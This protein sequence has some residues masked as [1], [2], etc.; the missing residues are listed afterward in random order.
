M[1]NNHVVRIAL[2]IVIVLMMGSEIGLAQSN[3]CGRVG[4]WFGRADSGITWMAI[5]LRGVSA[6][7]G[8]VELDWVMIDPTLGGFFPTVVRATAGKGVWESVN[9]S[10]YRY[11]W[12]AYG[13]DAAGQQVFVARASG[14]ATTA[15][16]NQVNI[17]YTLELFA[18][19][20]DIWSAPPSFGAITGT[21]VE[22]RMPMVV[23]A[24]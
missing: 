20:Q 24:Q 7:A 19:V 16:C 18:P 21:A 23:V 9:Q 8:Q 3:N 12:V 2:G 10:K 22:K 6:A 1:R 11:T 13:L 5:D 15:G 14:F 17:T 4:T